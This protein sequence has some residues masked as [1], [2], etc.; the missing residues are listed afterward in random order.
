MG[1]GPSRPSR[2]ALAVA[3]AFS[4]LKHDPS[5]AVWAKLAPEGAVEAT[6]HI[7][8]AYSGRMRLDQQMLNNALYRSFARFLDRHGP[9]RGGVLHLALR[10]RFVDEHVKRAIADGFTQ[11]AVLGAG[12]DTLAWRIAKA[13]PEVLCFE[14]DTKST[15]REKTKAL[16]A[17]ARLEKRP[18][19]ENLDTF[20]IDLSQGAVDR[21]LLSQRRADKSRPTLLI[22]EGLLMYLSERDARDVFR[23]AQEIA[24]PRS[25]LI[26]S[27]LASDESG[28]LAAGKY[29]RA[30]KKMVA[31]AGE[32]FRFGIREG[33]LDAF[34]AEFGLK[35]IDHVAGAELPKRYAPGQDLGSPGL[36]WEHLAVADRV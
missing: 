9:M 28:E 10:K 21:G 14:I 20:V 2:T 25:R 32:P 30:M 19:P 6:C 12:Y 15:Q 3:R 4:L 1:S 31:L 11:I 36:D 7:L 17:L 22:A 24:T 26:F 29:G 5:L 8:E 35:A 13:H 16:E 23:A 33:Q 18:F 34:L 27:Y